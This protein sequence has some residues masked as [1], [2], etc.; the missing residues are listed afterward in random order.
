VRH[1]PQGARVAPEQAVRR[2]E[3]L[4]EELVVAVVVL[5]ELG[6]E[7]LAPVGRHV[8]VDI[9]LIDVD[10]HVDGGLVAVDALRE[11]LEVLVEGAVDTADVPEGLLLKVLHKVVVVE[12]QVRPLFGLVVHERVRGRSGLTPL[13]ALA[14][15]SRL[16]PLAATCC[17]ASFTSLAR[18]GTV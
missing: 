9:L 3:V 2:A 10:G 6:V 5:F 7:R 11:V 17:H 1:S 18:F 8:D 12:V 15:T 13:A 16:I 14:A 4:P